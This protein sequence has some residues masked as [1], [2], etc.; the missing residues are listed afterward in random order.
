MELPQTTSRIGKARTKVLEEGHNNL[1]AAYSQGTSS[2]VVVNA[3]T[4]SNREVLHVLS[5]LLNRFAH[6]QHHVSKRKPIRLSC[7]VSP[8]SEI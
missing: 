6:H 2:P 8:A 5:S 7:G 3:A 1:I 4:K